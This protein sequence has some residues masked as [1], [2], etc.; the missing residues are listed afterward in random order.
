MLS[1]NFATLF[2]LSVA[3]ASQSRSS[4]IWDKLLSYEL[5]ASLLIT[6]TFSFN[7][8]AKTNEVIANNL[9]ALI[10]LDILESSSIALSVYSPENLASLLEDKV[11]QTRDEKIAIIEKK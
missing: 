9:V 3:F 10:P 11:E 2:I 7:L 4:R 6:S 8:S 5:V 1:N